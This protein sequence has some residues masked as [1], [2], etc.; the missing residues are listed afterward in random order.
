MKRRTVPTRKLQGEALALTAGIYNGSTAMQTIQATVSTST[1]SRSQTWS[2]GT[3]GLTVNVGGSLYGSL[4]LNKVQATAMGPLR[5]ELGNGLNL[6][7]P[8]KL[9][10]RNSQLTTSGASLSGSLPPDAPAC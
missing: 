7:G 10:L 8:L 2:G 9:D 6:G 5:L 1:Q 4:T 3:A